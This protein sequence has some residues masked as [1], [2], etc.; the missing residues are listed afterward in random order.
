MRRATL[1]LLVGLLACLAT[2]V[3]TSVAETTTQRLTPVSGQ[4]GVGPIEGRL[5]RLEQQIQLIQ[6]HL[7]MRFRE[8]QL[9]LTGSI[10]DPTLPDQSSALNQSGGPGQS[11]D[12][13]R[14]AF[15]EANARRLADQVER[16]QRQ[17]DDA[18]TPSRL[19]PVVT[20]GRLVVQNLT[21]VPRYL[22]VNGGQ[23]YVLP[24]RTDIWVPYQM[25]QAYLPA[26]EMPKM[27]GMNLWRWTG[28]DYE[29]PIEIKE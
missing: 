8:S 1:I 11:S 9:P 28:R 24:G 6:Q 15:L 19:A 4:T 16:L 29:M 22:S 21:S 20:R 12:Y 13:D 17:L 18:R 23:H 7:G 2:S 10:A 26:N 27:L 25:V 14:I 5:D 3:S